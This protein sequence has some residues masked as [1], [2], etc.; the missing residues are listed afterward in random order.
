M[1]VEIRFATEADADRVREIYA[2]HVGESAASFELTPPSTAEVRRRVAK[3]VDERPWLVCEVDGTV[4]GY[5]YASPFS[6]RGAYRWSVESSVYV[7]RARRR[8]GIARGLY[9]SLFELLRLQGFYNVYAG[10]TLPNPASVSLH[11]SMGFEPV[12]TYENVGYKR[13]EWRDVGRWHLPLR[14]HSSGPE[15][16]A[17]VSATRRLDGWDE[18]LAAGL[19]SIRL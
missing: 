1:S 6:D 18:A 17:S 16:P 13:G 11:E 3:T 2:P 5:A 9:A 10:V 19:S 12:G 15:P 8:N 14:E 7:H 4:A